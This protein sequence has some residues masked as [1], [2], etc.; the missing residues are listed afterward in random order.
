MSYKH[1]VL[2]LLTKVNLHGFIVSDP[3]MVFIV[4]VMDYHLALEDTALGFII[5]HVLITGWSQC[6]ASLRIGE[7]EVFQ[8]VSRL[9]GKD[10][11]WR[12]AYCVCR[13]GQVL[14]GTLNTLPEESSKLRQNGVSVGMCHILGGALLHP[15]SPIPGVDLLVFMCS[16]LLCSSSCVGGRTFLWEEFLWTEKVAGNIPF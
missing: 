16:L 1:T 11:C 2:K 9:C 5:S 10:T 3:A 13:M 6:C 7:L 4:L 8:L 12:R 14:R 15:T